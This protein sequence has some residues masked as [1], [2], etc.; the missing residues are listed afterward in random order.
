[1]SNLLQP[2]HFE[3]RILMVKYGAAMAGT[4][5]VPGIFTKPIAHLFYAQ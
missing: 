2:G 3:G 1:M 5:A 4:A